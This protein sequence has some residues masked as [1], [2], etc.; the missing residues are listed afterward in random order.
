MQNIFTKRKGMNDLFLMPDNQPKDT[1]LNS[2]SQGASTSLRPH[3]TPRSTYLRS[4]Q[5]TN[6]SSCAPCTQPGISLLKVSQQVKMARHWLETM[7]CSSTVPRPA[8]ADNAAPAT[9]PAETNAKTRETDKP[10]STTR[11]GP[12]QGNF[13]QASVTCE[14]AIF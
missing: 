10:G 2:S 7:T 8:P 1:F 14:I 11:K 5:A 12:C 13:V 6:C 4:I 3:T 9:K